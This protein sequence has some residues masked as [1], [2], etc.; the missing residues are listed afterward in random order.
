LG[1]LKRGVSY[2]Q[3]R[4]ELAALAARL[5]REHPVDQGIGATI[6]P[7]ADSRAGPIRPVLLMLCGA[8]GM[9]LVIACANLA[10]LL[11][12]RN[13]ARSRELA[14]RAALGAGRWRLLRQ[15][16]LETLVLS[17]AGAIA[18]LCLA[19]AAGTALV[20]INRIGNVPYAAP[21]NALPQFWSATPEPRILLFTLGISIF[22][23]ILFGLAPAFTGA[24]V[25]LAD[26]LREGGRSGTAG[27]RRWTL[28]ADSRPFT[29]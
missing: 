23:A 2:D 28:S 17:L 3:A 12:A 22:T 5:A 15:L 10:S 19:S 4:T 18:G 14:V 1:R 9:V 6:E 8:V 24:R 25:S 29:G 16:L 13:S 20:R 11:V 7:L 21:S 27:G 26:T